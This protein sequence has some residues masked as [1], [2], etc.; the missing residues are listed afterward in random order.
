MSKNN[1]KLIL[2]AHPT[3]FDA[4]KAQS[5]LNIYIYTFKL[6]MILELQ[7]NSKRRIPTHLISASSS[8]ISHSLDAFVSAKNALL[9]Y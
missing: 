8:F 7:K 6:G 3:V 2:L 4:L 1:G 5:T 9:E